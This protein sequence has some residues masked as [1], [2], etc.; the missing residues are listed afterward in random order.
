VDGAQKRVEA[1]IVSRLSSKFPH[2]KGRI[3]R[4]WGTFQDR[5]TSEL[6]LA[7]GANMGAANQVL[8]RFLPDYN[9]RFG[10]APHQTEK[11]WPPAPEDFDRMRLRDVRCDPWP[12]GSGGIESDAELIEGA[13]ELRGLAH[14]GQ[15]FQGQVD[16]LGY[17]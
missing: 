4:L 10:R 6:R 2:A 17:Q 11:A 3:E 16:G 12:E 9:R 13:A 7:G 1:D 8:R 15:F 14:S 5:R